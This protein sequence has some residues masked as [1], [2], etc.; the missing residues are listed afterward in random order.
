MRRLFLTAAAAA[1]AIGCGASSGGATGS[2][3]RGRVMRGP[4][5]PGPCRVGVPCEAPAAGARLSF[6]RSGRVVASAT[7]NAKGWYRVALKSGRYSVGTNRT[8][9]EAKPSPASVTVQSGR[10]R[11]VDFHLDTGMR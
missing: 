11:R 7:T 1:L 6:S 8:G 5:M 2:G 10:V 9:F 4:I 3:L